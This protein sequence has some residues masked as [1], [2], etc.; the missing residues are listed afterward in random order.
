MRNKFSLSYG[1][2]CSAW[3]M[4]NC[5]TNYRADQVDSWCCSNWC[6]VDKSCPSAKDSL[7]DGMTGILYWSDNACPDDTALTL[8]CPYRPQSNNTPAGD[9]TCLTE[10]V[11]SSVMDWDALGL[12]ST[13]YADYGTS[14]MPWD[15]QECEKLYPSL[16]SYAMWCCLSWCWVGE[17]CASA[18]AST[19]WP[20]QYFSSW[21][22]SANVMSFMAPRHWIPWPY[23]IYVYFPRGLEFASNYVQLMPTNLPMNWS[24]RLWWMWNECRRCFQLQVRRCLPMSRRVAQRH[25]WQ[26]RGH[27][28]DKLWQQRLGEFSGLPDSRKSKTYDSQHDSQDSHDHF[29]GLNIIHTVSQNFSGFSHDKWIMMN[30]VGSG[31]K[32][33]DSLGCKSTWETNSNSGWSSS[34]T[35]DTRLQQVAAL[36]GIVHQLLAAQKSFLPFVA[37]LLAMHPRV[38]RKTLLSHYYYLL[39]ITT[40]RRG[41]TKHT[42][43]N[44]YPKTFNSQVWTLQYVAICCNQDGSWPFLLCS[45]LVLWFLVLCQR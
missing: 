9:C 34:N 5:A 4:Q 19:L 40:C 42:G 16:S 17:T 25:L 43:I 32:P 12:N 31:C 1:E 15:S 10:K 7:N 35:H 27:F 23:D 29:V 37:S 45:G 33:W 41:K 14:C 11:P 44:K 28:Q 36:R 3:D 8:Q 2:S 21:T 30:Y 6:Y 39:L 13:T 20:G 18:R 24:L 38:L 26:R 22:A